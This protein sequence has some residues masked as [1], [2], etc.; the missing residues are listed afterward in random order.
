MD[1]I[2]RNQIND[3]EE[4]LTNISKYIG[5]VTFSEVEKK[6]GE[7]FRII[8]IHLGREKEAFDN[9]AHKIRNLI[10]KH[11]SYIDYNYRGLSLYESL[12]EISEADLKQSKNISERDFNYFKS[13]INKVQ[14]LYERIEFTIE[15]DE[16]DKELNDKLAE[17][18]EIVKNVQSA[19]LAL[20]GQKTEEIY[21]EAS[22]TYLTAARNYE[23]IFYM[24]IG[25]ALII[26]VICL[27]YFPYSEA[28]KVNFIFSKIL[29]ASLVIT[30]GTLFLRKAAHL[31]KLHEQVHQTSLELQALPLYLVNVT[32]DHQAEIYKDL[33]SK[34]FG[35]ELDK[36][37][38]DKIGDLMSEQVK[39]SLEVFKTSSEIMKSMKPSIASS[40]SGEAKAMPKTK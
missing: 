23:V 40:E 13:K 36:T 7:P 25:A 24:L 4:Y 20:D 6:E 15:K 18:D 35:K 10:R 2:R 21:S 5:E 17:V 1:K 3:I 30:L 39:T 19:K 16:F 27:A 34:Y 32:P 11:P 14:E 38:H 22:Q 8:L 33:A 31:R 37:Q 29:T 28:T 12:R 26:T 9:F